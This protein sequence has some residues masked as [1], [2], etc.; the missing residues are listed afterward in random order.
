MSV[1][2][3]HTY[4]NTC[5]SESRVFL[6]SS[7]TP[8]EFLWLPGCSTEEGFSEVEEKFGNATRWSAGLRHIVEQGLLLR[9]ESGNDLPLLYQVG[10]CERVGIELL[11]SRA[12]A[13]YDF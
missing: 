4:Y 9:E 7:N 1:L 12:A 3:D 8:G 11:E 10:L 6:N 5:S 2:Y 13:C